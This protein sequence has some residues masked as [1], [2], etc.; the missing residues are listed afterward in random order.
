MKVEQSLM[1][2]LESTGARM[3]LVSE[4]PETNTTSTSWRTRSSCCT[5]R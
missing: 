3:I 5:S 1:A 2:V 4:R